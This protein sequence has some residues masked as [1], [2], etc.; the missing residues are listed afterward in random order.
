M[1]LTVE[2][3]F[4]G[5]AI[6]LR[7]EAIG[8]D[9]LLI[10][11]GGD[12]AHVGSCLL[13]EPHG[14]LHPGDPPGATTSVLNRLKHL[15]DLVGREAAEKVAAALGSPVALVCGIH[16]DEVT[17]QEIDQIVSLCRDMTGELI[18]ALKGAL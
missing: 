16:Y 9:L 6:S 13:A 15:D 14:G 1:A 3:E 2:R 17:P 7:A 10:L 5:K 18:A 11:T 12:R 8:E 4:K